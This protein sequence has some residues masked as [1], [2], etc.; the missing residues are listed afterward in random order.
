MVYEIKSYFLIIRFLELV[1]KTYLIYK[2]SQAYRQI[3]ERQKEGEN[4]DTEG[5]DI[6]TKTERER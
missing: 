1:G 2:T 3:K 6:P 4:R 5:T